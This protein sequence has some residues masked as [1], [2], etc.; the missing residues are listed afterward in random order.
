[1]PQNFRATVNASAL[2][3]ALRTARHCAWL[4][5]YMIDPKSGAAV[6]ERAAPGPLTIVS[7]ASG[8]DVAPGC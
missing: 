5:T 2:T 7:T 1:M 3:P 6:Q 4:V 8:F